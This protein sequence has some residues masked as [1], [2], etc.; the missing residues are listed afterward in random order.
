MALLP[1]LLGKNFRRLPSFPSVST[2]GVQTSTPGVYYWAKLVKD[3][4]THNSSAV[5]HLSVIL[6]NHLLSAFLRYSESSVHSAEGWLFVGNGIGAFTYLD[7]GFEA[8]II[9]SPSVEMTPANTMKSLVAVSYL[10]SYVFGLTVFIRGYAPTPFDAAGPSLSPSR[11]ATSSPTHTTMEILSPDK[12]YRYLSKIWPNLSKE[13]LVILG[14][15]FESTIEV[16]WATIAAMLKPPSSNDS[17]DL[18]LLINPSFLDGTVAKAKTVKAQNDTALYALNMCCRPKDIPGWP[19]RWL[20]G[21]M[22]EVLEV[23]DASLVAISNGPSETEWKCTIK[24][25]KIIPVRQSLLFYCRNPWTDTTHV[26][27]GCIFHLE[28]LD[29]VVRCSG[30]ES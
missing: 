9:H 15:P 4:R 19:T 25:E 24:G 28:Q 11:L 5:R 27:D 14:S 12:E 20:M 2:K 26:V 3:L 7:Q 16:A 1:A 29:E 17:M 22:K 30:T 21:N 13:L 23:V 18:D 6:R 8:R 10:P